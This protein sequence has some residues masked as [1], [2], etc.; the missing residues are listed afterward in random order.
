MR[1]AGLEHASAAGAAVAETAPAAGRAPH[2]RRAAPASGPGGCRRGG[3]GPQQPGRSGPIARSHC[4]SGAALVAMAAAALLHSK[5]VQVNMAQ[6]KKRQ[7]YTLTLAAQRR[8]AESF[9]SQALSAT[10]PA[11][12]PASLALGSAGRLA[13]GLAAPSSP[14]TLGPPLTISQVAALIGCSPWTVR[15]KLLP[16]GLPSFRSAASGKLIFYQAQVVR[17]IER[18]QQGGKPK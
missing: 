8:K 1:L 4:H 17:W 18:Q 5:H 7:A 14:H 6:T 10:S 13:S 9:I 11:N 16:R 3:S 12:T 15:Q 2:R